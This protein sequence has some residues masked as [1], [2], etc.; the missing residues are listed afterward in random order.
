MKKTVIFLLSAVFMLT[1]FS[2]GSDKPVENLNDLKEKY[3]DKEFKNCDEFIVAYEEAINIYFELIY[4]VDEGDEAAEKELEELEVFVSK[5]DNDFEKFENECP[6]KLKALD[7][8][9]DKKMDE[10]FDAMY[11]GDF[12]EELDM[13]EEEEMTDEEFAEILDEMT[14]EE[15]AEFNAELEAELSE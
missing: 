2:C 3:T 15:W 5:W 9:I 7:E 6:E 10:Y 1:I 4:K 11:E 8:K 14:D 12:G 13:E